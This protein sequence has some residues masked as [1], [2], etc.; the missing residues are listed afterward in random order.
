MNVV[1]ENRVLA[2]EF[3]KEVSGLGQRSQA[4]A[5][6]AVQT[7]QAEIRQGRVVQVVIALASLLA[8][9]LIGWFYVGRGV[10]RRLV[11]LQGS[12]K[13]IAAGD[14]AV[15]VATRGSDEIGAMGE[16]LQV[17]KDNMA[18]SNRLRAE[19]VEREKRAAAERRTEMQQLANEFHAAVGEIIQ[20]VS[21]ASTELEASAKTLTRHR[22]QYPAIV[23]DGGNRVGRRFPEC[24][25]GR[26]RH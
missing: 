8:A 20:T 21:S 12:M 2:T 22:D 3:E 9:L 10:V 23:R 13:A 18:E 15:E 17:F 26:R 1:A 25:F 14:L 19:R 7:S 5:A 16:A 11:G 4:A 6:G 24:R